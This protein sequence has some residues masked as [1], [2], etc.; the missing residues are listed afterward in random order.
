M[1]GAT[2]VFGLGSRGMTRARAAIFL[3]LAALVAAGCGDD[4][5]TADQFRDG[6]NAAI[7]RL[8]DV[9]SNIEESGEELASKPGPQI[10]REFDRIA[11]TAAQTR[12][13]L[14][15]LEPPEGA[16][17]E[18]DA[19]LTAIQDGVAN[20]RAV[21]DAARK[22]NQQQFLDATEALSESGEEISQAEAELKDAVES[23]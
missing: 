11:E 16:G 15:E 18:F 3:L 17:A 7:E 6:Y 20:I 14:A 12:A 10:A 5:D 9:N 4:D 2:R 22:E 13:D 23:D 21:A 8:N 1:P 19:L